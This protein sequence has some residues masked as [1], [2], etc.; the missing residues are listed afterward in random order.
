MFVQLVALR[1]VTV[2]PSIGADQVRMCLFLRLPE[3]EVESETLRVEIIAG[4]PS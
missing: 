2:E 1:L 3:E 4:K